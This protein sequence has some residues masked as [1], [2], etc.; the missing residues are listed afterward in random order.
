MNMAEAQHSITLSALV[1]TMLM[2][3]QYIAQIAHVAGHCSAKCS[4]GILN[5]LLHAQCRHHSRLRPPVMLKL[6]VPSFFDGCKGSAR[7]MLFSAVV[8]YLQRSSKICHDNVHKRCKRKETH[9]MVQHVCRIYPRC[10]LAHDANRHE[11]PCD[12]SASS[13]CRCAA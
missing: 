9:P 1:A 7:E 3:Q 13:R 11:Q 10:S 4:S 2:T 8:D 6:C 5:V 12:K